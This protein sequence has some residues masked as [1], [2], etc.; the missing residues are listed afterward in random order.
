MKAFLTAIAQGKEIGSFPLERDSF[1][2]GRAEE[3]DIKLFN[4]QISR[5]HLRIFRK[6]GNW[7]VED[8]GSSGGT[9]LNG[10]RID[11]LKEYP[12][13]PGDRIQIP[14]TLL[15]FSE[16][17]TEIKGIEKTVIISKEDGILILEGEKREILSPPFEIGEYSIEKRGNSIFLS[18]K[19]KP[20]SKKEL[21]NGFEIK[22]DNKKLILLPPNIL[23]FK[24]NFMP[25][26]IIFFI[27]VLS[28]F[29]LFYP[30]E[31][32]DQM[33]IEGVVNEEKE[34]SGEK[35]IKELIETR[36]WKGARAQLILL[37]SSGKNFPSINEFLKITY[38]EEKNQKIF[39]EGKEFFEKGMIDEAKKKFSEIPAESVYFS[40]VQKFLEEIEKTLSKRNKSMERKEIPLFLSFY[41]NGDIE[42]AIKEAKDTR[43]QI[44]LSQLKKHLEGEN[45]DSIFKA[46]VIDLKIDPSGKGK[47]AGIIREKKAKFYIIKSKEALEKKK[48]E[49]AIENA[50]MAK[51]INPSSEYVKKF[52][53]EIYELGRMLYE[54]AYFLMEAN[55]QKSAEIFKIAILLLKGT[56]YEKRIQEMLKKMEGEK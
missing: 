30:S 22:I 35:R 45:P 37:L 23:Y 33:V 8:L 1:V 44:M 46:E 43:I 2:V 9:I 47:I 54:R 27:S 20:G 31:K 32:K 53:S 18:S 4:P 21:K 56:E 15:I 40:D 38:E 39:E 29:L 50:E 48:F 52:Y 10:T 51:K 41:L 28:G 42:S 34:I 25:K 6:D 16:E 24:R 13:K 55:P 12:L 7:F 49:E 17:K 26:L 11:P 36:D 5:K 3:C 19:R 14:D